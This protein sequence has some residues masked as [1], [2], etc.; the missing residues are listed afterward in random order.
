M[1]ENIRALIVIL[2]LATIFFA[3]AHRTACIF[4]SREDFIRRRNLWFA[5]T[6]T[7]F[8]S[9]SFWLYL[10]IAIPL[11]IYVRRRESNLPALYFFVLFVLPVAYI[12]IPGMG[13]VNFIFDISNTR[14]LV[15]LILLPAFFVLLQR[16]DTL[17]FGRTG[18]DKALAAYLLLSAI[19]FLRDPN[20]TNFMRQVFYAFIDVFV[21][22]FVISR[23]LK[24]LQAF[25]DAM[26]SLEL[27]IMVLALI[28]SFE[29]IKHWLLYSTLLG[30][31]GL[32]GQIG[33]LPREG[34]LRAVASA[35]QPIATGYLML[36]GIGSYL[37]LRYSIR[38][39]FIRRVAI[40]VLAAGAVAPVSRGP[41]LGIAM[42]FV[43]FISTG[44][45]AVRRLM[46]LTLAA[47]LV[48]PLLS[49]IPG[50]DKV[51]NLLP[52]IGKTEKS[53]V[54]YREQLITNSMIVI[55]RNLWFG[56][57][58]YLNTPEMEAMRQ[59][60]GIIDIVNTYI[61]VAL[62]TGVTGLALFVTFFVLALHG[63]YRALRA[64]AD[65]QSEEYLLGRALLATLIGILLTIFTVSNIT[66]IPIMYWSVAG[67]SVAYAQMIL[68]STAKQPVEQTDGT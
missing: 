20:P 22:Y 62:D 49:Q 57:I 58:D 16:S 4:T 47:I 19:L 29:F 46:K 7:G 39:K 38:Q 53:N 37:F 18:P 40:A 9:Y 17:P 26:A 32:A 23:S 5:L 59:G 34:L 55:E 56:S 42:L 21:P 25:R 12:S 44:R 43:V 68:R 1:P 61:I 51:I 31:L 15:L 35:G 54:D 66:F 63:L 67:L 33:Y 50:G 10:T 48:V 3:F 11:I 14:L 60:Q 52:F 27:A 8:V 45:H 36:I 6:I 24:N 65:K 28:A 41:W 64:I 13:L 30:L 2:F